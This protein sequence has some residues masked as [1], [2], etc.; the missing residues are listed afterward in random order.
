VAGRKE[1]FVVRPWTDGPFVTFGLILGLGVLALLGDGLFRALRRAGVCPRA[2]MSMGEAV[3]LRILLAVASVPWICL[4]LDLTGIPIARISLVIWGVVIFI[5]G[6]LLD[7]RLVLR[8]RLSVKR[9]REGHDSSDESKPSRVVSPSSPSGAP[10]DTGRAETS[11][12]PEAVSVLWRSPAAMVLAAA[13]GLLVVCSVIQISLVP[14]R[15]YDALVGYDLVGKIM[16][17]EGKFRSTVFTRICFNAQCV[18]APFTATNNGYWY[19]FQPAIPRLWIPILVGGF[20]LVTW[21][22]LRRWTGSCTAAALT[23]FV[24]YLPLT[25]IYELTVAQTDLPAAVFTALALFALIDLWLGRGGYGRVALYL[26]IATT[27][28]TEN[29]LFGAA[30]MCV[31][32]VARR[33]GRWKSLWFAALPAAFFLFWNLFFVRMLI[34]YRPEAYFRSTIDFAPARML[35]VF[36]RAGKIIADRAV[37]GEFVWLVVLLPVL[38]ALGRSRILRERTPWRDGPDLTGMLLLLS[39]VMF[40]FYMP[41]FYMWNEALNPLWTM[42]DTF[43]RGFLRF[44][45]G[46]VAAGTVSPPVLWLLRKCDGGE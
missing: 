24:M 5:A 12:P 29:V 6:L 10:P 8:P 20:S 2:G 25:F 27:A 15:S 3:G 33:A 42:Q 39:A 23:T 30:M 17:L 37:F 43:K 44:I 40:V 34:G 1:P 35:E 14:V 36:A 45:P 4:A 13:A 9:G 22:R 31:A 38:W 7:G 46:L 32:L 21:S 26:L 16:A 41:F 28:R 18:Y 19:I 11:V